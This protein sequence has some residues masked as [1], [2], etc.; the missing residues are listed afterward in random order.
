[1]NSRIIFPNDDGGM[2]A[3]KAAITAVKEAFPK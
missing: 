3:W 2:D 1:M